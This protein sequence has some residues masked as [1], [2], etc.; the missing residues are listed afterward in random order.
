MIRRVVDITCDGC[1]A[2][3]DDPDETAALVRSSARIDGW[4]LTRDRR[5]LCPECNGTADRW[6]AEV[7]S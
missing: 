3:Y 2:D 1:L 7:A 6:R 4:T 5:D